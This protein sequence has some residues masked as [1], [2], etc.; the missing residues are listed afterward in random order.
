MTMDQ[1]GCPTDAP[2]STV[3]GS[4]VKT[5]D[6]M[7]ATYMA[8]IAHGGVRKTYSKLGGAIRSSI[9]C[10]MFVVHEKEPA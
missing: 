9:G 10:L 2:Q 5:L 1:L 4:G 6:A 8:K 7:S 3:R